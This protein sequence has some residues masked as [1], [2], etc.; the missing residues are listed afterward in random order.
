MVERNIQHIDTAGA[1]AEISELG[2]PKIAAIASN[3]A[4]KI[5]DLKIL[6][7]NIEQKFDFL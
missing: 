6:K 5:Y 4:A 1:A 2:D 7:D 3:M